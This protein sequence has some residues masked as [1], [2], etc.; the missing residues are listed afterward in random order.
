[1]ARPALGRIPDPPDSR[2]YLWRQRVLQQAIPLPKAFRVRT[3]GPVLNQGVKPWCVAYS[4]A[5]MKMVEEWREHKRWP[6]FDEAWLYGLCKQQDGSPHEDGTNLRTALS[7]IRDKGYRSRGTLVRAKPQA[8]PDTSYKISNF[9]RLASQRQIKEA[10]KTAGP[11]TFGMTVD[12]GIFNPVEGR[13]PEP[14]PKPGPP[15][16]HAMLA[17]GW[18]DDL[19]AFR[20]KNSWGYDWGDKGFAWMPYSWFDTY[21]DW[22]AWKAMDVPDAPG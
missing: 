8:G 18:D 22:D 1:M 13:I 14:H 11:V 19:E 21:N 20:I 12:D 10:I 9:V 17:T 7:I 16:G 6:N 5:S 2:D 15:E 3:C 4:S